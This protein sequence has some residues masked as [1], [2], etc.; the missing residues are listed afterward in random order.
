MQITRDKY[1]KHHVNYLCAVEPTAL[2]Y[3]HQRVS[4]NYYSI[5]AA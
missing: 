5:K 1:A 4:G 3:K 2:V